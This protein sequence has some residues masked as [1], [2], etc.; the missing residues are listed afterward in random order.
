[1]ARARA[2]VGTLLEG[3]GR[4][5][6]LYTVEPREG[7]WAVIVECATR[8]VRQRAELQA[9]LGFLLPPRLQPILGWARKRLETD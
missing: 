4:S 1:M 9:G 5:A 7:W 3:L 2:A 6:H 8:S